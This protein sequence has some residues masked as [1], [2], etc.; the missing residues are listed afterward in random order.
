MTNNIF[1]TK[2]THDGPK[3]YIELWPYPSHADLRV[4][5]RSETLK[6]AWPGAPATVVTNVV[7]RTKIS[8]P[9][10]HL[11]PAMNFIRPFSEPRAKN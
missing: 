4:L 1:N 7:V 10:M 6:W 2:P 5:T 8:E 3:K 9:R 11:V